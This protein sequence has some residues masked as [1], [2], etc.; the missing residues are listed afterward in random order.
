MKP[1][2]DNEDLEHL[3][4]RYEPAP[5]ASSLRARVLG[6]RP[7]TKRAWPWAL[8]AAALLAMTVWL[9][10]S[11]D[12]VLQEPVIGDVSSP[13]TE[14]AL[15]VDMLGGGDDARAI[16]RTIVALDDAAGRDAEAIGTMGTTGEAR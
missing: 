6:A 2:T 10:G 12:R 9:H 3:L 7:D 14:E 5:P 1:G 16:A 11:R 8:S 15:L 4:Q 13:R